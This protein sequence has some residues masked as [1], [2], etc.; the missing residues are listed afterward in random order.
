M[1]EAKCG[2]CGKPTYMQPV[3]A[4]RPV[5]TSNNTL[6]RA[7]AC[8]CANCTRLSVVNWIPSR[9]NSDEP[10]TTDTQIWSPE[11]VAGRDFPDVPEVIADAATEAYQCHSISAY[12][13]S[14]AI[15][16][17]VV[18]AAAKARGATESDLYKMIT[19][20]YERRLIR[21]H[22]KD[23]AHEIRHLGNSVAHG[24]FVVR[25]TPEESD[26]ILGLMSELLH[27]L[28]QSPAAVERR[29]AARLAKQAE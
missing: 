11:F 1:A 14:V 6:M 27:E 12:R 10:E 15:A 4:S 26:E 19:G 25:I 3:M 24:D 9:S 5:R 2:W 18:E 7:V 16:R 17:A 20:L 21:E 29:K 23:A 13:G 22:I 8:V 28:F